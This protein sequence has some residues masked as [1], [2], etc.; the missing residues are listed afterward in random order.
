MM[1]SINRSAGNIQPVREQR[2]ADLDVLERR[3]LEEWI[4]DRPEI[5]GKRL[6]VITSEYDYFKRTRDRLDILALDTEGRLVVIELKRDKADETTDLQAIKYASYCATLTAEDIQRDYRDFWNDREE[7]EKTQEEVGQ[8]FADFL[9]DEEG[10]VAL[11]DDGWADFELNDKPR[12]L[13]AAGTF[14]TEITSPV[15]WLLEEYGLDITCVRID[16]YEHG[17]RILLSSQRVI[18]LPEAEEYMTRR[19]KKQEKQETSSRRPPAVNVLIERG[20]LIPG[21][22]VVFNKEKL[23]DDVDREWDETDDFWRAR[24]TGNTGQSDHVEWL[25]EE[26]DNLYS[27]T[28]LAKKIYKEVTGESKRMNGYPR[29]CHT[30]PRFDGKSLSEL[31]NADV[32][33]PERKSEREGDQAVGREL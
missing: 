7:T 14:G 24:V 2:L 22:E 8:E 1:F 15:M 12:I 29:W 3:D 11:S 20:V 32:T 6:L 31:R 21:D 10:R 13:L 28:G 26:E 18:P 17:D 25:Y 9:N 16:A 33:T 23:P 27:F 19:R 4:I 30:D 5:L